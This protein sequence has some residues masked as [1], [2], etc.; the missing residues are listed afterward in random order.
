[1]AIRNFK[2]PGVELTQEFVQT[3]VTGVSTL[4]VVVVGPQYKIST[5]D[6]VTVTAGT[7]TV[8]NLPASEGSIDTTSAV[9]KII[10]RDGVFLNNTITASSTAIKLTGST[11]A[12][13]GGSAILVFDERVASGSASKAAFGD[14][15]PAVDGSVDVTLEG[16]TTAISAVISSING[17]SV[18]VTPTSGTISAGTVS[19]VA[20]YSVMDAEF[21]GDNITAKTDQSMTLI[22][23]PTAVLTGKSE[24][25]D[26]LAGKYDISLRYSNIAENAADTY[27]LQGIGSYDEIVELFGT[28]DAENPLALALWLALQAGREN[29]VYY[30]CTESDDLASFNRAFG[31]LDKSSEVYSV[32]PLTSDIS[33]ITQCISNAET[34]SENSESKVRRTIWYGIDTQDSDVVA[35]VT[36]I[37]SA[38]SNSYR[39]Q[40]VWADGALYNG[41]V[42]PNYV[43]AAAPAGMRSY[44]P[45]WRPLSNLGYSS[46]SLANTHNITKSQLEALGAQGIWIIGEGFDGGATN[47]RQVTTAVSNNLNL[48]EE[49][50]VANA[51]SIA[52]TLCH[53]GE[54]LVGC[55][56]ISPALLKSLSDTITAIMDNYLINRTGNA[57]IGPQLLSW[58]LDAL[59]QHEVLLDHI[60]A[61]IT[62]EPPKPFNRF[63]MTLRIV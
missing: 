28:P 7:A 41:K 43:L 58:S 29:I 46:F 1:M 62:C 61:V 3:P 6:D 57:Y 23:N 51:D 12:T 53:V 14:L 31:V 15:P 39:A 9:S 32:V 36:A 24:A 25:S 54:D 35:G 49:S 18:V 63:V 34:A 10:V 13:G 8:I 52:L 5:I 4:G 56:N 40:A 16:S 21:S 60:Y 33:I 48:D 27:S 22:A 30:L 19:A 2:F 37:R 55:S 38:I 17:N 20:F 45:S 44:E 26:L 50:I 47:L 11:I 59:Y 42:V